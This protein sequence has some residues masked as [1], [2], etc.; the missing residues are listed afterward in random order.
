M[1]ILRQPCALAKMENDKAF[2]A[3]GIDGKVL[4]VYH[5]W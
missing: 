4:W 3:D 2:E 5:Q 1:E